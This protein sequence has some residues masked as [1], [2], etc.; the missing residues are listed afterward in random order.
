MPQSADFP[1]LQRKSFLLLLIVVSV[2]FLAILFPFFGAVFWGGILA[3]L[4]APVQ[5]RLRHRWPKR[6]SHSGVAPGW[7]AAG[8]GGGDLGPD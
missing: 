6:R 2:A 4:F 7:L 8:F 1:D 5:R 3:L